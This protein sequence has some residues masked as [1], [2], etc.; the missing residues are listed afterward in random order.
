MVRRLLPVRRRNA[1]LFG[2]FDRDLSSLKQYSR[3]TTG[4]SDISSF[5][6]CFL[7]NSTVRA[8]ARLSCKGRDYRGLKELLLKTS[9]DSI[10]SFIEPVISTYLALYLLSW[11]LLAQNLYL[12]A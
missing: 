7:H 4:G 2:N 5:T 8:R 12:E 1:V 3:G 10:R 9:F 11:W 6:T